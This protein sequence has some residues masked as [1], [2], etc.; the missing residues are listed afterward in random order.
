[1]ASECGMDGLPCCRDKEPA[2]L[3][4]Q[5]CCRDPRDRSR[6]YCADNCECGKKDAFCC[7][8]ETPCESG[9]AC[10]DHRC[11][12]CGGQGQP[13]CDRKGSSC[14]SGLIQH[15]GQCVKCGL[16][17]NPCCQDG[18]ACREQNALTAKHAE[19]INRVC[20]KCGT[21]GTRVCPGGECLSGYLANS[22]RCYKCGNLNSA[23]CDQEFA[24]NNG[25]DPSRDL[26]CVKGFC[27]QAD[28][29]TTTSVN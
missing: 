12:E 6:T 4:G 23:C 15:N 11:R 24:A 26:V 5:T 22:H 3:Y 1:M 17:G 21:H 10:L 16:T 28:K 18:Q 14:E 7:D 25:C 19:C 20:Q 13:V 8:S 9:L 2:C 27:S 29:A